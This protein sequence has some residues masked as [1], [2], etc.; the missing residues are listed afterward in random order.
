MEVIMIKLEVSF[1]FSLWLILL[2]RLI[3]DSRCSTV[4]FRLYLL[5]RVFP[6]VECQTLL[7]RLP[8]SLFKSFFSNCDK[9]MWSSRWAT[10]CTGSWESWTSSAASRATR[11]SS[12]LDFPSSLIPPSPKDM[13]RSISRGW[14]R[15]LRTTRT[16]LCWGESLYVTLSHKSST[17]FWF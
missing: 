17:L 9:S 13:S 1:I 8:L 2:G 14:S 15:R 7:K 3:S 16:I 5:A 4:L 6:P 11:C 12:T 10:Q